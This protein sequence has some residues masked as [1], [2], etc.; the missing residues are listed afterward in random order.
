MSIIAGSLKKDGDDTYMTD[1][2]QTQSRLAGQFSSN[3]SWHILTLIATTIQATGYADGGFFFQ[4][5]ESNTGSLTWTIR[6]WFLGLCRCD[7]VMTLFSIQMEI[8]F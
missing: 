1:G 2:R 7:G 4:K 3:G 6:K 8:L 5:S